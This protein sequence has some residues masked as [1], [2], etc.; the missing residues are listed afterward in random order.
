MVYRGRERPLRGNRARPRQWAAYGP[1]AT[2]IGSAAIKYASTSGKKRKHSGKSKGPAKKSARRLPASTRTKTGIRKTLRTLE[3][4]GN[5]LELTNNIATHTYRKRTCTRM[6]GTA[7]EADHVVFNTN[8]KDEFELALNNLRYFDPAVPGTLKTAD[9]NLGTYARDYFFESI[10]SKIRVCNNFTVPVKVTIYCCRPKIDT[11]IDPLTAYTNGLTDQVIGTV[12]QGKILLFPTD[13][14]EFNKFW[15]IEQSNRKVLPNG[16]V[17]SLSCR[18]NKIKYSA[19][20]SDT[21][22]QTYQTKLKNRTYF[23]RIEGTIGH[24]GTNV[25]ATQVSVDVCVDQKYVIRY[26]AGVELNDFSYADNSAG[27]ANFIG[28]KPQTSNVLFKDNI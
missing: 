26:D 19:N 8:T 5:K 12:N 22:P 13:I 25:G 10:T 28:S 6:D 20:F 15:N 17:M 7:L 16:G 2:A 1:V 21:H 3:K 9:T 14:N 27:T 24:S 11:N 18:E 23:V 4:K